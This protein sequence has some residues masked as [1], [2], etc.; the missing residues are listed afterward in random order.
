[1]ALDSISGLNSPLIQELPDHTKE[2]LNSFAHDTQNALITA[3]AVDGGSLFTG[4]GT[5]NEEQS[6]L[7]GDG[8]SP[9]IGGV[10]S[11]SL[12]MDVEFG[13]PDA[14]L[15]IEN[16]GEQ[17]D[18]VGYLNQLVGSVVGAA[19]PD[20]SASLSQ[21]ILQV[22]GTG[23]ADIQLLQVVNNAD[24]TFTGQTSI[25]AT[26]ASNTVGVLNLNQVGSG[27]V[28]ITGLDSVIAVGNGAITI[29][30]NDNTII[31]GD[32]RDQIITGGGGNDTIFGG[33]GN[34]SIFGGAGD[35]VFGF[36]SG[37]SGIINTV[38]ED[39]S[40][41]DAL[42][43]VIDGITNVD[44]LRA[45][46]SSVDTSDGNFTAHFIDGSTIT[47]VGVSA[48]DVTANLIHFN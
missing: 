42:H 7:V 47:L 38:I 43:F 2:V 23:S 25:V 15:A 8:S 24:P 10:H 36:S 32:L 3:T 5:N 14:V 9:V 31:S 40:A 46:I 22:A 34:D 19:A 11:G 37:V 12:V 35:D 39:F 17:T 21:A 6:I 41:G 29:G 4:T 45:M 20:L 48:E 44:Q 26:P 27:G 13:T 33:A 1:M 30:G 18:V 16:H 28:L